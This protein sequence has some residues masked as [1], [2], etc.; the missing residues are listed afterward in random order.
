MKKIGVLLSLILVIAFTTA[1]TPA[2]T[3]S[4]KLPV[5]QTYPFDFYFGIGADQYCHFEIT[6][7]K[8][9]SYVLTYYYDKDGYPTKMT[10]DSSSV[11]ATFSANGKT[12][13]GQTWGGLVFTF[14]RD[15]TG[16]SVYFG[17]SNLVRLPK[18]GYVY[19]QNDLEIGNV[20]W[21]WDPNDPTGIYWDFGSIIK[22][23]GHTG[24]NPNWTAFCAYFAPK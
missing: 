22:Q 18:Y 16:I 10:W 1:F 6:E 7:H 5:V 8:W 23:L 24:N 12:V 3:I 4:P 20:T 17:P 14:K 19:G 21:R 11:K 2:N 15:G 9:G 13:D